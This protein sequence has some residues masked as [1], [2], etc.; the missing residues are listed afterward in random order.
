MSENKIIVLT[1]EEIIHDLSRAFR[2]QNN[3]ANMSS[4]DLVSAW[5]RHGIHAGTW[6]WDEIQISEGKENE[7]I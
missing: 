7:T 2:E 1:R 3:L 4:Q 6:E 5:K